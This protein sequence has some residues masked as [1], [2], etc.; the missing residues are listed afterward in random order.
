M[1]HKEITEKLGEIEKKIIEH[2]EGCIAEKGLACMDAE[3]T[4]EVVDMIKDLADAKKNCYKA[5]YYETVV[6]AMEDA[7]EEEELMMKMAMGYTPR[8]SSSTGRYMRP[9]YVPMYLWDDEDVMASDGMMGYT[10]NGGGNRSQSGNNISGMGGRG[11]H[12]DGW[13][14]QYGRPYEEWRM[15]K[16]SYTETR[17]PEDKKRMD[18]RANE[19][20]MAS[21]TTIREVFNDA[22]PNQKKRLKQDLASLLNEMNV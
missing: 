19:H 21:I 6:E 7:D 18:D 5:K 14:S 15:A 2:L 1:S 4:G 10:P 11:G 22:D 9:G 16:R 3:E 8:R 20:I 12:L 17:S 13:G